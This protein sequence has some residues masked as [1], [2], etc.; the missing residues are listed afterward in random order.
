MKILVTQTLQ[1]TIEIEI[2]EENPQDAI[3]SGLAAAAD[4]QPADW[5]YTWT[6]LSQEAIPVAS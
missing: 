6:P 2:D 4:I 5:D 1:R 3:S